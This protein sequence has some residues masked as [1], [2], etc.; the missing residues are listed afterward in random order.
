[1]TAVII[2]TIAIILG[3][4]LG[5]LLRKGIPQSVADA[6]MKGLGLCTIIIGIQGAVKEQNIL[7]LI[8]AVVIGIF[9]GESIDLDGK[10]NRFAERVMSHF[11]DNGDSAKTAEAFITA[12]LIM[13]VGAMV[14]VGSL[15]AGLS[16][17]YTMLYTKSLLDFISG[18]MLAATLGIGVMGSGLF[19]FLFQGTIVVMAA[20][21]APYLSDRLIA[22][23]NCTGCL[24][25]LAI[26]LNMAGLS[27]FKVI[28]FLPGLFVVPIILLVQK[29]LF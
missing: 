26:G 19:T 21:I 23:I 2:N 24:L 29:L 7:L 17:N 18:I 14:I 11:R 20:Y 28:N 16:R 1:M 6:L 13:N 4:I 27:K 8:M 22:E 9:I 5:L 15:D 25:I 10:I 12:C 3:S